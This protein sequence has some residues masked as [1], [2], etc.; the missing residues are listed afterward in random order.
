MPITKA[1]RRYATAL[2]ELSKERNEVES[3]LEDIKFIDN[4]LDGSRELV[5][6]LKSPI[7]KYDDKIKVLD[8]LFSSDIEEATGLFMKLLVKKERVNLLDQITKA[9]IEKYKQLAGII[10]VEVYV[11]HELSDEQRQALHNQLEERTHKKVDMNIT[12]DE[13][14]RGG[15]AVRIDDTVIDG[16]VKHKLE[17]LEE[18]FLATTLE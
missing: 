6:F 9:F 3:I 17:E 5:V 4:T 1:A 10:T 18:S 14:L 16:T 12:Q 2:L 15:M 8:E 7:I 13:S 11:A